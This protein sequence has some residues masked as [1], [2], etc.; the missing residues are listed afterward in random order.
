MGRGEAIS[1]LLVGLCL[2]FGGTARGE[3]PG[4]CA[5][6]QGEAATVAAV[7]PGLE[8]RLGDGRLIR[9][10]G[11]DPARATPDHPKLDEEAR[12]GLAGW[13]VGRAVLLR[14]AAPAPDRWNRTV[15]NVDAATGP[16]AP[17]GA[18]GA[19][20]LSVA[21]A[22]VD[23]GWARARPE[24]AAHPCFP[25]LLAREGEARAAGLG[26][27]A[28]AAY[29]VL[30][31]DDRDGI[32]RQTGGLA[33]VEG[34]VRVRAERARFRLSFEG[35]RRGVDATVVRHAAK[36]FARA[37]LD[38]EALGGARLRV[39]GFLDDRFG[40]RIDVTDP[41]QV[42]RLDGAAGPATR[43]GPPP[44]PDPPGSKP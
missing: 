29:A 10:P 25:R 23:A 12:A 19:P 37:G 14:A 16:V 18:P 17:S 43:V 8:L 2:A 40:P 32:A 41:D 31:P 21:E 33:L 22:L 5:A 13:L 11:I 38:L 3:G 27:W 36:A 1:I 15:A 6:G 44:A 4:A 42:E 24:P 7:E 28:D 26:L 9:L 35:P 39:R 20:L 30:R 34:T